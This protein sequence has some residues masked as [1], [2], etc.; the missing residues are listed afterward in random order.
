[1]LLPLFLLINKLRKKDWCLLYESYLYEDFF[2][3]SISGREINCN[4]SDDSSI[5]KVKTKKDIYKRLQQSLPKT[6]AEKIA[7]NSTIAYKIPLPFNINKLCTYYPATKIVLIKRRLEDIMCSL[8]KKAWFTDD[9]L[10]NTGRIWPTTNHKRVAI[11]FFVSREDYDNWISM[12]AIHKAAYYCIKCFEKSSSF[13]EYIVI[14]YED[15]VSKPVEA[16]SLLAKR[17]NLSWGAKTNDILA[18]IHSSCSKKN[19]NILDELSEQMRKKL[20]KYYDINY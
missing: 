6:K 3:N 20:E 17:L 14:R 10:Y 19:S 13:N 16:A 8:I 2:I 11:P 7:L 9:S 1:M 5:Y 18:T 15:L 4:I 12:D